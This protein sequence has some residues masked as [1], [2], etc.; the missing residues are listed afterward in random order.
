MIRPIARPTALH[1]EFVVALRVLDAFGM[2]YAEALR[3]LIPTAR[4][5]GIPRPS[6]STVRR[7]VIE[8]RRRK[9][10]RTDLLDRVLTDLLV[11]RVPR[12][13]F[14]VFW[15]TSAVDERA[16]LGRRVAW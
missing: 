3:Q 10:G 15:N 8:E 11:G 6:Y 4:R 1:P 5:L 16:G 9:A 12:D 13:L 7:L 2:P 14:D